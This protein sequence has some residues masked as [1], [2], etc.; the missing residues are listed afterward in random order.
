[1]G[2]FHRKTL[3]RGELSASCLE[4]KRH[5]RIKRETVEEQERAEDG[6]ALF[7]F[8]AFPL[9]E[10]SQVANDR[11]PSAQGGTEMQISLF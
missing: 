6:R 7:F 1:M 5:L 11:V 9:D 8:S 10:K 2:V 3:S 4:R